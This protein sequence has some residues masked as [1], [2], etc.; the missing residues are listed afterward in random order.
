MRGFVKEHAERIERLLESVVK[1]VSERAA[2]EPPEIKYCINEHEPDG[3][4]VVVRPESVHIERID[5]RNWYM[6]IGLDDGRYIQAFFR[7]TKRV[8]VD[9]QG[10]LPE[11]VR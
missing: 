9:W 10:D 6:T 7:S 8:D 11:P 4:L 3:E 1:A 2:P 5:K